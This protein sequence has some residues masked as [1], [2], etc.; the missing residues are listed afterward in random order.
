MSDNELKYLVHTDKGQQGQKILKAAFV[1]KLDAMNYADIMRN[2]A[3][4]AGYNDKY[5]VTDNS[6]SGKEV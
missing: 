2:I 3:K 5:F 1:D 4:S 6:S